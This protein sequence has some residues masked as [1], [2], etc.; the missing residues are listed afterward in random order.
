[1]ADWPLETEQSQVGPG[2]PDTLLKPRPVSL[3]GC[4]CLICQLYNLLLSFSFHDK[5]SKVTALFTMIS[6]FPINSKWLNREWSSLI[7]NWFL[8]YFKRKIWWSRW[9]MI[10]PLPL[11]LPQDMYWYWYT[12]RQ[13]RLNTFQYSIFRT[14]G[15]RRFIENLNFKRKFNLLWRPNFWW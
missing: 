6:G 14:S 3:P 15:D 4:S 5:N 10:L 8:K 7:Y 9:L 12:Q 1:M 2:L 13:P 11:W